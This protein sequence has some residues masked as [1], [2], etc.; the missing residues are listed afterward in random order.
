M[1]RAWQDFAGILLGVS[2]FGDDIIVVIK[3]PS[4]PPRSIMTFGWDVA[5]PGGSGEYAFQGSLVLAENFD[6]WIDRLAK[7]DWCEYGLVPGSIKALRA[8]RQIKLRSHFT[9]LNPLI[10]WDETSD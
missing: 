1:I 4:A 8:T 3:A 2:E 5:G 7:D 10:N 9:R 6:R